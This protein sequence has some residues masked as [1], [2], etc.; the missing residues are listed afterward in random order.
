MRPSLVKTAPRD[1]AEASRADSTPPNGRVDGGSGAEPAG[2]ADATGG[3]ADT[4]ERPAPTARR[5]Q[6]G[7][8]RPRPPLAIMEEPASHT[9]TWTGG[10]AIVA[11][12][13]LWLGYLGWAIFS[14]FIDHGLQ[15][16]QFIRADDR[17]RHRDDLP[18]LLGVHVPAGPSG[19]ALPVAG[20]RP[21]AACR[22]RRLHGRHSAPASR[23]SCR[24]TARTRRSCGPPCC[25]WPC[26]STPGPGPCSCSTTRRTPPTRPPRRASP[27]A[28][29][30]PARSTTC[31]RDPTSGS[32]R[33]WPATR[34]PRPHGGPSTNDQ[35]RALALDYVWAGQWLREQASRLPAHL[36]R[37]RLP[38]RRG[39]RCPR[40]GHRGHG[41]SALRRPGRRRASSRPSG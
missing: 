23:C 6:W 4:E 24:R 41:P 19:C 36:E 14:Q 26:R 3:T 20:A 39:A 30:C 27:G 8:E 9:L 12:I 28:G 25:P 32:A 15:G 7:S 2:D 33:R 21:R 29:R 34:R 13:M 1:R 10:F 18:H 22:D 40:E 31:S 16:S 35:V 5:R 11:T 17:L 37:R 38:R